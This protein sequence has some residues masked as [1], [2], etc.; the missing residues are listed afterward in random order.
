[1][2]KIKINTYVGE[3]ITEVEDIRVFYNPDCGKYGVETYGN[4]WGD[5]MGDRWQMVAYD[6]KS[7]AYTP[8]KKVAERW[9]DKFIVKE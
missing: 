8:Y 4:L 1:M 9:K 7:Q 3:Y 6:T 2:V 5:C